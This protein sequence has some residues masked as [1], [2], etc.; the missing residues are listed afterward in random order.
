MSAQDIGYGIGLVSVVIFS[1]ISWVRTF[2]PNWLLPNGNRAL[3]DRLA[4]CIEER[5]QLREIVTDA[6]VTRLRKD[7][8][9][10]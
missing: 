1:A 8:T 10:G 7:P 9:D 2:G 6:V 4:D 5:D 3:D